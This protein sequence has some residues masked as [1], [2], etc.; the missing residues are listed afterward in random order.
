M[1][2]EGELIAKVAQATAG[3]F[4][5]VVSTGS[6]DRDG[7]V[8]V[9]GAFAPLPASIPVH[10][11]HDLRVQALVARGVPTYVGDELHLDAV[12]ASTPDAQT[13]RQK[14][15]DGVLSELSIVFRP[16][17]RTE[18]GGVPHIVRGDLLAA[19]L[20]TVPSNR[21]T[22]ILASRGYGGAS[23]PGHARVHARV[24]LAK[25]LAVMAEVDDAVQGRL[26]EEFDRAEEGHVERALASVR[27]VAERAR[28]RDDRARRV[29]VVTERMWR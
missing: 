2:G 6:I 27:G 15:R 23:A 11:N 28:A 7:E 26:L 24:V 1:N 14:V 21:D 22:R 12:F 25:A 8:V 19:D 10:M 9:P 5:A 20:V 18:V 17:R 3:G 13:V 4:R 16:L 29:G